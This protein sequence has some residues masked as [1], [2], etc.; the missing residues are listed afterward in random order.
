M[1][2]IINNIQ[3]KQCL[4]ELKMALKKEQARLDKEIQNKPVLRTKKEVS[5]LEDLNHFLRTVHNL[6]ISLLEQ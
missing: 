3:I 4:D 2:K 5:A 6:D 1:A